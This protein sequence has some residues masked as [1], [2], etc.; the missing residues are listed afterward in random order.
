MAGFNLQGIHVYER[1]PGTQVHRLV[2]TY[3][4]MRLSANGQ[5]V[6]IQHGRYWTAGGQPIK[7]KDLPDWVAS[8]V[9]KCSPQALAECGIHVGVK[10]P[11][12]VEPKQPEVE[13]QV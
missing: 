1:E 10:E 13:V 12:V 3:P 4:A 6:Y 9:I 7:S 11:V 5:E 2:K 8:E